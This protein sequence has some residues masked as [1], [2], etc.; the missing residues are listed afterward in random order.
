MPVFFLGAGSAIHQPR[1]ETG[2]PASSQPST[3][4][5]RYRQTALPHAAT[6]RQLQGYYTHS[7]PRRGSTEQ[8][9]RAPGN[10]RRLQSPRSFDGLKQQAARPPRQFGTP[11]HS[12]LNDG[13]GHWQQRHTLPA[14]VKRFRDEPAPSR[15]VY[16]NSDS[17]IPR[18]APK[19]QH[20]PG[21]HERVPTA[22]FRAR[23]SSG[24]VFAGNRPSTA[25]QGG[26]ESFL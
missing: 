12:S 6:E 16:G 11:L 17:N 10:V 15:H 21:Q 20:Q 5:A 1:R 22:M 7:E 13:Q 8:G 24:R 25:G 18:V 14:G 23:P 9:Q 4:L 26:F 19:V 2:R 3:P